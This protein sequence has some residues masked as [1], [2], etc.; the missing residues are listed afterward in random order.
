MQLKARE[1]I[2]ILLLQ[3]DMEMRELANKMEVRLN[4]KYSAENLSN[5][6]RRGSITYNE[7]LIIADILGYK[8]NFSEI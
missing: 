8:I 3:R 4:K 6:L 2:K 1:Q 5:K 7:V